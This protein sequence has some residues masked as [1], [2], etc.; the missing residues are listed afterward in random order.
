MNLLSFCLTISCFN[1]SNA[2]IHFNFTS[3]NHWLTKHPIH[4]STWNKTL[5]LFWTSKML[6]HDFTLNTSFW[7]RRREIT[8]KCVFT[9]EVSSFPQLTRAYRPLVVSTACI[10]FSSSESVL[11][12]AAVRSLVELYS[13]TLRRKDA[14]P[15]APSCST[16]IKTC[17]SDPST[18]VGN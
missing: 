6:L 3:R 16:S 9:S 13:L 12:E 17:N 2:L 4:F 10:R 15:L 11:P 8:S 7:F 1:L 5:I 18:D 14:P